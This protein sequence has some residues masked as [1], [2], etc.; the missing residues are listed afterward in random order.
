MNIR[1]MIRMQPFWAPPDEGGSGDTPSGDTG[2]EATGDDAGGTDADLSGGTGDGDEKSA[3]APD[4]VLGAGAAVTG[5]ADAPKDDDASD[6]DAGKDDAGD[7]K[8]KEGDDA[9]P[10]EYQFEMPEGMELDTTMA[11]AM[12][13]LFKEIGITQG[14]ANQLVAAYSGQIGAK[15]EAD[16]S[17]FVNRVTEWTN[18]AQADPEIGNER[19]DQTV[20]ISNQAL[21]K[22]G[23]PELT[24]ALAET[25]MSNHPEMIRFMT[26]VASAIGE[27]AFVPGDTVDTSDVPTEVSWYGKTTPTT[28]RT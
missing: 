2:D 5:D 17:Q 3:A 1:D 21:Q 15:A 16:A 11:E 6:K 13:P 10:E 18:A 7:D 22:L 19:W 20:A 9:V 25:G 23:T 28:K 12:S 14:Q 27:D 4:A 24:V 8:P 26:R